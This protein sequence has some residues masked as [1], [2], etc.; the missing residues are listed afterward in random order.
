MR[1]RAWLTRWLTAL[2]GVA[3]PK[4]GTFLL[5]F[6]ALPDWVDRTWVR[7]AML[8][9][10]FVIPAVV[11]VLALRM[12]DAKDRPRGIGGTFTIIV[13]GYPYTMALAL[14]LLLMTVFAPI[15]KLR[16]LARRWS[17]QH[18]PVIVEPTDYQAVVDDL[19]LAL[20]QSGIPM[21]RGRPGWMLR[22]PTRLLVWVAGSD[23]DDLVA[24]RLTRLYAPDVEVILHPSDMVISGRAVAAS[25]A[26][27]AIAEHLTF[28]RAYLTWD[29]E[30]NEIEDALRQMWRSV[31]GGG[32]EDVLARLR[33]LEA[34]MHGLTLPYEEWEV[35]FRQKLQVERAALR[36]IAGL[37]DRASTGI[38]EGEESDTAPL[39]RTLEAVAGA[40][41]AFTRAW[42][43]ERRGRGLALVPFLAA[44]I[45][46]GAAL[47]RDRRS[48][49]PGA[50][51]DLPAPD[52]HAE[53]RF[54]KAA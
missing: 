12:V 9:A 17:T 4:A 42:R 6:V 20:R 28:T 38:G 18:V 33:A 26:R 48:S 25:R 30:A 14:T 15:L 37:A 11:G 13:R 32:G 31:E 41:G 46:F 23:V 50:R 45:A 36:R 10:A 29:A 1:L 51:T 19:D 2:V 24:D 8:A 49:E 43:A 34:R 16:D 53:A 44:A 39:Q 35:L 47:T 27:A 54:S 3:F 21:A 22:A 5:S 40:A 7:L 52:A